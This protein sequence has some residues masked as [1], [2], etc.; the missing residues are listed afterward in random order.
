MASKFLANRSLVTTPTSDEHAAMSSV[1]LPATENF[2]QAKTSIAMYFHK[3]WAKYGNKY[4]EP[5]EALQILT[6][7]VIAPQQTGKLT[8]WYTTFEDGSL[9]IK[10]AV[11]EQVV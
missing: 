11:Y 7:L 5:D 10:W 8:E 3:E 6:G 1:T 2:E 9:N 4:G